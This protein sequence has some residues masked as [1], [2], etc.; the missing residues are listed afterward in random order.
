MNNE[1]IQQLESIN[2]GIEIAIYACYI[3]IGF[4]LRGFVEDIKEYFK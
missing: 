4:L 3:L 2:Q 1:I